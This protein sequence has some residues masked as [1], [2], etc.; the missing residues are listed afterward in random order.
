MQGVMVILSTSAEAVTD[1]YGEGSVA[2]NVKSYVP[3]WAAET[4]TVAI[5]GVP[6]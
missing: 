4:L 2:I 5:Y 1:S 6:P 3:A